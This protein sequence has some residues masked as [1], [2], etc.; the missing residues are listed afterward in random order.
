MWE[1]L[2][3]VPKIRESPAKSG[4]LGMYGPSYVR[5]L[6]S[7]ET[8]SLINFKFIIIILSWQLFSTVGQRPQHFFFSISSSLDSLFNVDLFQNLSILS[9]HLL[10]CFPLFLFPYIVAQSV[11]LIVYLLSVNLLTCQAHIHFFLYILKYIFHLC[12]WSY[13]CM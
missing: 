6:Q 4:G 10:Y 8:S 12:F 13:P 11:I 5:I 1:N 7:R 9:R 2:K 3:S